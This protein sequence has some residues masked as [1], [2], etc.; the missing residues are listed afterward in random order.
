MK[1]T[2]L[3]EIGCLIL[4][5][6]VVPTHGY[7]IMKHIDQALEGQISI[8]PATLYT[9]LSKLVNAQLCSYV[10]TAN[11]KVYTITDS[12]KILLE[13]EVK[14]RELTLKFMHAQLQ[15]GREHDEN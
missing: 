7:E 12:G 14:K 8:G 13:E 5:T 11:K 15:K 6:L 1:P 2:E 3:T 9:T 4:S 10:E